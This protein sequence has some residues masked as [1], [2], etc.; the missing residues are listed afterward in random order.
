M[1]ATDLDAI[2]IHIEHA[3]PKSWAATSPDMPSWTAVSDSLDGLRDLVREGIQ[4]ELGL[5][6][7]NI[8]IV[9]VTE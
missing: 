2:R 1:E 7:S 5:N 9:E 4:F 8:D 6:P 3:G